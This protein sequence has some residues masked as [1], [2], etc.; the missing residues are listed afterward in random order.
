M[1]NWLEATARLCM[2]VGFEATIDDHYPE[3]LLSLSVQCD[4]L[5]RL[6]SLLAAPDLTD[7][8]RIV[9]ASWQIQLGVDSVHS[10]ISAAYCA[11]IGLPSPAIAVSCRDV[12]GEPVVGLL[13]EDFA[14]ALPSSVSVIPPVSVRDDGIAFSILGKAD[15]LA[16]GLSTCPVRVTVS[17]FDAVVGT[18]TIQVWFRIITFMC[19]VGLFAFH[20]IAVRPSDHGHSNQDDRNGVQR[21]Q[22]GHR[23]ASKRRHDRCGQ[24]EFP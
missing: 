12:Y 21:V 23:G 24:L 14:I 13:A 6:P 3:T 18:A 10:R 19:C 11:T 7:L 1:E 5:P 4:S 20:C 17:A 22:H 15:C 2:L 16:S 9:A 8:P